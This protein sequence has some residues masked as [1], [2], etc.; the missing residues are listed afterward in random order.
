MIITVT[1]PGML[2][3]S[4]RH[5]L[6]RIILIVT[7]NATVSAGTDLDVLLQEAEKLMYQDKAEYYK[8]SGIERRR[9]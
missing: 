6:S 7:V 8:K 3:L 9:H 4:M 2:I 1:G 5:V